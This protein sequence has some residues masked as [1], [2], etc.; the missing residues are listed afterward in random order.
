[1]TELLQQLLN[2]ISLHPIWAGIVIFLVAMGESL[3]VIGMLIP[4]AAMMIGFGTL[5]STGTLEF[6]PTCG[7]AVAGAIAGDGLSFLLGHHY[8]EQLTQLWPFNKHPQ[9]LERGIRFFQRYGGKSVVIGRFVGPTRA[10]IPM[11][12]GMMGMPANRFIIANVISA[13][14][15]APLYLLPGMV[16]GASLGLAS[17][18]AVRLVILLLLLIVLIWLLIWGI[19]HLFLLLHPHASSWVQA[20]FKWSQHHPKLKH[21]AAAL[22]DPQHP[23]AR[24]LAILATLLIF[25]TALS[26]LIFTA[27]LTGNGLGIDQ[28]L[29]QGIQTLRTPWADH[30]MTHFSRLADVS[31]IATLALGILIFLIWQQQ[32]NT[33]GY[34]LAAVGFGFLASLILK[35]SI[36]L[37]RPDIGIGGL[38]PY[39]FPSSHTLRA[40]VIF[41][42][43]S[44]VIARALTPLQRW[45]PYSLAALLILLVALSRLY[46]GVHWFSDV[47]ASLSLGLAWVTL[48]GIAYHRH[49]AVVTHWRTL[50]LCS[51]MLLALT[52][53]LQTWISHETDVA[54]YTPAPEKQSIQTSEWWSQGWQQQAAFRHDIRGKHNHPLHLQYAGTLE[55]LKQKLIQKGWQQA[56]DLHW[57]DTLKLLSPSLSLQALPVLPQVHDGRHES[58]TMIKPTT[59]DR[60]LVLRLWSSN[61]LLLPS[62]TTLWVGSVTLQHHTHTLTLLHYA[63]TSVDFLTPMEALYADITTLLHKKTGPYLLLMEEPS[64]PAD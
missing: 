4:G 20:A 57:D 32:W 41:G 47:I 61:T 39:G 60:R 14:A 34:W 45:L 48:L 33:M 52:T 64:L 62:Q 46:L 59:D 22:A 37:P 49:T 18:V 63:E 6:W 1:M 16:L 9:S 19:K 56:N 27:A 23:E 36:Q 17:E 24:G 35:Y 43:L 54:F 26:A 51:I 8:R 5:I 29:L 28:A 50:A 42:F 10:I 12:A 3:A 40:T 44:V 15:W 2:W 13:L 58:L 55:G 53:G 25:T 30:L 31:V 21:I 38:S 7:W 11:V